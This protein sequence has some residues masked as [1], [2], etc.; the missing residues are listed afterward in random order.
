[1][2]HMRRNGRK[3]HEKIAREE[4]SCKK[5][6]LYRDARAISRYSSC[7]AT[8]FK[9]IPPGLMR[10]KLILRGSS[11]GYLCLQP[12][13]T[14]LCACLGGLCRYLFSLSLSWAQ[15]CKITLMHMHHDPNYFLLVSMR[16]LRAVQHV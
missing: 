16:I 13:Q 5:L 10:N 15:L 14:V 7:S 9:L 6:D 3:K 1:M 2:M 12:R 4:G 11:K 8:V